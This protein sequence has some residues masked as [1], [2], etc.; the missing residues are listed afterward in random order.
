MPVTRFII[1]FIVI[2]AGLISM[3]MGQTAKDLRFENITVN[4]GLSQSTG[5]VR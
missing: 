1:Y 5:R 4:D 2:H 3:I